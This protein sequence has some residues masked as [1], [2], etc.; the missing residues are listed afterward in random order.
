MEV[1]DKRG[2]KHICIRDPGP[3]L[4]PVTLPIHQ[5]LKAT[6]TQSGLEQSLYGIHRF[7]HPATAEAAEQEPR[8]EHGWACLHHRN[9]GEMRY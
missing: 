2:V 5:I 1:S 3:L 7:R 9:V 6:L 8:E 4:R